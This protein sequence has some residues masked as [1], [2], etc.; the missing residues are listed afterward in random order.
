MGGRQR[1]E[2]GGRLSSGTNGN[3]ETSGVARA[4]IRGPG[5]V[6]AKFMEKSEAMRII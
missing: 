3:P 1:Q 5:L 4:V 6:A 2:A